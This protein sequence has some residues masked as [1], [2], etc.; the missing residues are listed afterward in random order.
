VLAVAA[1]ATV[2]C[3]TA[4]GATVDGLVSGRRCRSPGD[5]PKSGRAV[6]AARATGAARPRAENAPGGPFPADFAVVRR[7]CR[8]NLK[9]ASVPQ[10]G[11]RS[12]TTVPDPN[13]PRLRCPREVRW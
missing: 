1:G 5:R 13:S 12:G 7:C 3:R 10:V 2:L 4:D 8:V 9:A 6:A 11:L